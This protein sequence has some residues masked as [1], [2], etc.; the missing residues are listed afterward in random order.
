MILLSTLVLLGRPQRADA[1][2]RDFEWGISPEWGSALGRSFD[3][4][5]EWTEQLIKR[6]QRIGVDHVRI[7]L[8]MRHTEGIADH[9]DHPALRFIRRLRQAN[10]NVIAIVGMGTSRDLPEGM[11]AD[12]PDYL[13]RVTRN[14]HEVVT[15]L[16]P[17]GVTRFQVENELNA[18]GLVTNEPWGWRRGQRWGD[19]NFKVHLMN[20][21]ARTTRSAAAAAGVPQVTLSTNF[22]DAFSDPIVHGLPRPRPEWLRKLGAF[23]NHDAKLATAIRVLSRPLDRVGIDFYPDYFVPRPIARAI[24]L[25]ASIAP[26]GGVAGVRSLSDLLTRRVREYQRLSQKTVYIAEAG[27]ETSSPFSPLFHNAREQARFITA[28]ADAAR[29]SGAAGLTWFR[30]DDPPAPPSQP[31]DFALNRSVEPFVGIYDAQAKPKTSWRLGVRMDRRLGFPLPLPV[32]KRVSSAAAL[33]A[34][35]RRGSRPVR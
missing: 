33:R 13:E 22:Y 34:A 27:Y 5:P 12:D 28:V 8:A 7:D 3:Y 24:G 25:P 21:L 18:A 9:P 2:D 29:K 16:A 19:F 4:S 1:S 6:L 26:W 23:W 11:S 31:F 10:L 17:L 14:V 15:A 35:I 32:W 30:Y 20:S